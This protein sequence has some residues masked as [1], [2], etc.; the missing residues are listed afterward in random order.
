MPWKDC[1]AMSSREE[2]VTLARAE[3]ANISVLCRRFGV[4]RRTGYKWMGRYRAGGAAALADRSRRPHRSPARSGEDLE[5]LVEAARARHPAWGPR[6]LRRL[7]LN[8]GPAP[9]GLGGPGAIGRIR[10]GGGGG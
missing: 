6:K 1:S 4:S 5:R 3:G 9:G 10:R 8:E 7:L 2:F